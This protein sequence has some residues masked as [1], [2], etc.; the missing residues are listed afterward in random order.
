MRWGCGFTVVLGFFQMTN[1]LEQHEMREKTL[2][3]T[4]LKPPFPYDIPLRV[5][6]ICSAL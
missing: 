1:Q 4:R 5:W 3:P 2:F 6:I